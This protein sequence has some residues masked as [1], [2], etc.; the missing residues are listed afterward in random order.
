LDNRRHEGSTD[1]SARKMKVKI[2]GAA[3]GVS[4]EKGGWEEGGRKVGRARAEGW[5]LAGLPLTTPQGPSPRR[6][7][8]RTQLQLLLFSSSPLPSLPG[9]FLCPRSVPPGRASRSFSAGVF[10]PQLLCTGRNQPDGG[11]VCLSVCRQLGLQ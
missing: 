2:E 7:Q 11:T 10:C 3:V 4:W 6:G 5:W 8:A 1:F 9:D